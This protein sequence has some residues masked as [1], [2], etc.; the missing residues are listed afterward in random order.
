MR[1]WPDIF[2]LRENDHLPSYDH[3]NRRMVQK[4]EIYME[5]GKYNERKDMEIDYIATKR[6]YF[7]VKQAYD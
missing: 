6:N 4:P 5:A 1:V 2:A 7:N 3:G